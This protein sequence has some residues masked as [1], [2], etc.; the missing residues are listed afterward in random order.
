[1][2]D[3]VD[4]SRLA[5][6]DNGRLPVVRDDV[7]DLVRKRI[8]NEARRIEPLGTMRD[9]IRKRRLQKQQ[10]PSKAQE[11]ADRLKPS[12]ASQ[13]KLAARRQNKPNG[14]NASSRTL[15][16]VEKKKVGGALHSAGTRLP[17]NSTAPRPEKIAALN[18]IIHTRPLQNTTVSAATI[19]DVPTFHTT[20]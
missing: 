6:D 8:C 10:Y 11:R 9:Q 1:M 16:D 14:H 12:A 17:S 13:S 4:L 19:A 7:K 15:T 2:S 20:Y 18:V 5:I 3:R